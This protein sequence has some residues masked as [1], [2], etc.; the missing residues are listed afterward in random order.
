[1]TPEEWRRLREIFEMA[2]DHRPDERTAFVRQKCGDDSD[3]MN[4]VLRMLV[5]DAQS[6]RRLDDMA[7]A[8]SQAARALLAG[9]EGTRIGPYLVESKI[10]AG[11]MGIVYRATRAD[12][13][14]CKQVA[15]K[16]IQPGRISTESLDRFR[17]ER[18]I[19]AGL[20][21]PNIARI[22]DGGN[23]SDG[24]PYFVMEYIHG[25]P[26]HAYCNDLSIR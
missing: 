25:T 26:I 2:L 3:L 4:Q 1:M 7:I 15:L 16:I 11:G 9:F 17:Q 10:G 13:T 24:L 6:P 12:D 23:T 14:F 21:H 18:Q 8:S 22:L 20:D 5:A 19:L